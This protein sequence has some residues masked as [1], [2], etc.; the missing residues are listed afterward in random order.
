VSD[1]GARVA[2]QGKINIGLRVLARE[3]SGYHQLET[4]FAR[5]NLA[6]EVVVRT[7]VAA[8]S[9]DVR[10]A[11]T[12][13]VEKNLAWRAAVFFAER[14]GW[15]NGFAIE[16]DKRIPVGGGLGGGSADA[17]AVLRALNT[18]APHPLDAAELLAIAFTLGADVPY[19]TTTLP[20]ALA[21]GRGERMLPLP[22]LEPEPVLLLVPPFRISTA[23][24]FGWLAEERAGGASHAPPAAVIASTSRLDWPVLAALAVNDLE[25]PVRGRHPELGT[26]LDDLRGARGAHVRCAAMS[27][28]GSALFVVG[29]TE[30]SGVSAPPGWTVLPTAAPAEVKAVERMN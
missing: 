10:G 28:S 2:A 30:D 8:R 3:V 29:A 24:A 6:D 23:E 19:L 27:G 13:P 17:G 21:W 25:F 4:V 11:D 15:P 26:V 20:L 5:I 22:A 9:L 1:A 7:G 16:I 14:C 18:L 12:G